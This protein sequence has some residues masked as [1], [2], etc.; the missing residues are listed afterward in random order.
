[1]KLPL[2][3]V[4][5]FA[6]RLFEGNPAAVCPLEAWLSDELLQS[7][8]TEN[9]LSETVFFVPNQVG[10]DIRWFTPNGE[11]G[12]CGHATLACAFVIFNHIQTGADQIVFNS[13]S[14]QLIVRKDGNKL[15]MD[16]PALPFEAMR[17]DPKYLRL[18]NIAPKAIFK[19]NF[20]LL[21]ILENETE[22][23]NAE[24]DLTAISKLPY[25]GVIISAT[26][27]KFGGDIYSRC[28]YPKHNVPE[29]PVTGSA[30]CV[31]APYWCKELGKIKIQ[32]TQGSKRKGKLVCEMAGDRVLLSGECQLY[33]Q[34]ALFLPNR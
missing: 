20:D 24:L 15:V 3:Q 14:G 9:N 19:S 17:M 10:F 33:L 31:L 11:V 13:L 5:A 4:D 29:D 16:F 12:L 2:Y 22:V 1:M 26:T 32:A 7:I 8:A 23:E 18:I 25:R 21:F 27:N 6:S 34:G 30:H 28:F